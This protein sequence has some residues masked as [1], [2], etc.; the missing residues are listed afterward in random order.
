MPRARTA[1]I[2]L[3]TGLATAAALV[4]SQSEGSGEYVIVARDGTMFSAE[5][6]EVDRIRLPRGVHVESIAAAGA[7][8]T[9]PSWSAGATRIAFVRHRANGGNPPYDYAAAVE[10]GIYVHDLESEATRRLT[11]RSYRSVQWSPDVRVLA[12]LR[13]HA[14]ASPRLELELLSPMTGEV[15]ANLG[16]ASFVTWAPDARRWPSSNPGR[17]S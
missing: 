17:G 5:L 10:P 15:E 12:A 11:R 14:S 6:E 8:D 13:E 3:V 4:W 9:S 1:A 2:V 16:E 7:L